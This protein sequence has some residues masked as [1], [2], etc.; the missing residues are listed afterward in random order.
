MVGIPMAVIG[1]LL[2]LWLGD[3]PEVRAARRLARAAAE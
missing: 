1:T 3:Y 2:L